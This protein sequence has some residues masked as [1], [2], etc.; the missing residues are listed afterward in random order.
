[1]TICDK[2]GYDFAQHLKL[3]DEIT[4]LRQQLAE[5][6]AALLIE[7]VERDAAR[8]ALDELREDHRR[9]TEERDEASIARIK[10]EGRVKDLLCVERAAARAAGGVTDV[11][12]SEL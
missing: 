9:V 5:A 11:S 12:T 1:M 4:T 3:R 6:R 2:C 10:L 7:G 8:A